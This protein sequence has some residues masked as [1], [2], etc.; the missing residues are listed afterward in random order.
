MTEPGGCGPRVAVADL[1]FAIDVGA[2]VVVHK[3]GEMVAVPEERRVFGDRRLVKH[4]LAIG[5]GHTFAELAVD[6]VVAGVSV[7]VFKHG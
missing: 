3:L 2:E 6:G 4:P 7:W 1:A 5:D